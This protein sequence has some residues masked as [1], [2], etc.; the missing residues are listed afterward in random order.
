MYW[1]TSRRIIGTYLCTLIDEIT[2]QWQRTCLSPHG[3]VY[4]VYQLSTQRI[5]TRICCRHGNM[6]A[7]D[8]Q[9]SLCRPMQ[10][11]LH[12]RRRRVSVCLV[13]R[14]A[15]VSRRFKMCSRVSWNCAAFCVYWSV[16]VI[17]H[18]SIVIIVTISRPITCSISE[19]IQHCATVLL[20]VKS[21]WLT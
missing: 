18:L 21:Y 6:T 13:S 7:A 9:W 4:C 10:E 12:W 20:R 5:K 14:R 2:C 15:T 1:V 11:Q 3:C 17:L 8:Q 19:I 16:F